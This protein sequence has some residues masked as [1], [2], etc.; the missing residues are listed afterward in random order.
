M[1]R[2]LLGGEQFERRVRCLTVT[3]PKTCR[4]GHRPPAWPVGHKSFSFG[5]PTGLSYRQQSGYTLLIP[6][7][8][9]TSLLPRFTGRG[10]GGG[11]VL[12]RCSLI[13]SAWLLLRRDFE[14]SSPNTK[15][16]PEGGSVYFGS[17]GMTKKKYYS[18]S[19]KPIS[20]SSEIRTAFSSAL[21]CFMGA[22]HS[23][24]SKPRYSS[25][26]LQEGMTPCLIIS[27][28]KAFILT[29]IR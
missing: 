24:T 13:P 1:C 3:F 11:V 2:T 16:S 25:V 18:Y 4:G 29:W 12:L 17:C 15:P 26:A 20:F 10:R 23:P 21:R 22:V 7:F 14:G 27:L 9:P 19:S 5:A 6:A 8:V 28:M